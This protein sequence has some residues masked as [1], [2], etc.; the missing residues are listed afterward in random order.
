[1]SKFEQLPKTLPERGEK[2]A[3]L[4][5][6]DTRVDSLT[7]KDI[8]AFQRETDALQAEMD[9]LAAKEERTESE[10]S[11]LTKLQD[12]IAERTTV[13]RTL[14]PWHENND[15]NF[16][17]SGGEAAVYTVKDRKRN[18]PRGF[19]LK[20]Y[21]PTGS[22]KGEPW[23]PNKNHF[24]SA[25][26]QAM[27]IQ[28]AD[29]VKAYGRHIPF[30]HIIDSPTHPDRFYLAQ[31]YL[32]LEDPADIYAYF[33]VDF[34]PGDPVDSD[35][36]KNTRIRNECLH[37]AECAKEQHKLKL[38][39]QDYVSLDGGTDN[40]ALTKDGRIFVVD[41]GVGM[42]PKEFLAGD[43]TVR[44]PG[45]KE[46]PRRYWLNIALELLGGRT[47]KELREDD[48][49]TSLSKELDAAIESGDDEQTFYQEHC[50]KFE[51]F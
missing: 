35:Y 8:E 6:E 45:S 44:Y 51:S 29:M 32:E 28:Y 15:I 30:Q 24:D 12:T 47:L 36:E 21:R 43:A 38:A 27:Q 23:D 4:S 2:S 18:R 26:Y 17:V 25:M 40:I 20:S 1:M 10:E 13:F 16:V 11:K 34:E 49:Y 48:Y 31:E 33:P 14:Y 3:E 5:G 19:V 39:D 46:L 9:I 22:A 41:T 42:D 37:L 7:I 50:E